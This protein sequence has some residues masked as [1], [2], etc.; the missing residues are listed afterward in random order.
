MLSILQM[1]F[2]PKTS[3]G[4]QEMVNMI[5]KMADLDSEEE[6]D[7]TSAET[8]D[9]LLQCAAQVQWPAW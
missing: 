6:F 3:T 5:T 1:T 2:L 9:R 7:Y 8:V 4:Q